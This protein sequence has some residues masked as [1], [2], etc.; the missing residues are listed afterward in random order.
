MPRST[1]RPREKV[2]AA[3]ARRRDHG[4]PRRAH[5]FLRR[6]RRAKS[7]T[8]SLTVAELTT[9]TFGADKVAIALRRPGRE[10]YRSRPNRQITFKAD[11]GASGIVADAGRHRRSARRHASPSTSKAT[12]TP[13][14]RS[15]S[16]GRCFPATASVCRSPATS[17]NS[18]FKRRHRRR[19]GE[20]CA[21]L[22]TSPDAS[23]P[24]GSNLDASRQVEPVTG[25]F[26]PDAGRHRHRTHDRQPG[27][28]QSAAG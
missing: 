13:A 18:R 28:R 5:A 2:R 14:S 9:D 22:R 25:G 3:G 16:P 21:V 1:T 7:W 12:G 19:R 15:S 20:H 4:R 27:G 26:R 17:P 11:G 10:I 6:K 23:S 24:A 8:G